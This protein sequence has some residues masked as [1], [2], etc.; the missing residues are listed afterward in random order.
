MTSIRQ[1]QSQGRHADASNAYE[2]DGLL[3]IKQT[4]QWAKP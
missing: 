4:C 2:V 3:A 1:N